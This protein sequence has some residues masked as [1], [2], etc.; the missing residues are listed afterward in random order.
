MPPYSRARRLECEM[1]M[2]GA[3]VHDVLS[4]RAATM[5]RAAPRSRHWRDREKPIAALVTVPIV[6]PFVTFVLLPIGYVLYLSFTRFN[7]VGDPAWVGIDNYVTAL[8][9]ESWWNAVGNTFILAAGHMVIEIP[10]ALALAVLLNRKLF[11]GGAF[12][13]IYFV[14]HVISAAV[15]GIIF[16]FLTRPVGGVVNGLLSPLGI[17]PPEMDWLGHPWT[18]RLVLILASSW[19]GFGINTILFLV[20]LQTIPKELYESAAVEGASAWQ[21]F[22]YI[23]IPLL[24]PVLRIVL[25]LTIVF[26]MREF[27]LVKTLTNGGPAG[28]TDVMFTNLFNYFFGFDRAVQYGYASALGVI[29]S[30]I[31]AILSVVYLYF[32]RNRDAGRT[33]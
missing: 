25:M 5:R 3:M 18:A 29:A 8:G 14:P 12:R 19:F 30:I 26:S 11:F 32:S 33:R 13:T 7:G 1:H 2:T 24:A 6:A 15:M 21:R 4:D 17:F 22:R 23:V 10:L 28:A 31:V 9:D 16:Y 27:D 20:G